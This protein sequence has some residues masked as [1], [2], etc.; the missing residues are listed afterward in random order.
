MI[1]NFFLAFNFSFIPKEQNQKANSLALT[2]ST[3]MP[4]IGP[5]IKYQVEII[6]RTTIPYNIKHWKVFSDDLELQTF[7][8]TIDEFSNISIDHKS[9]EDKNEK[10][11]D[12]QSSHLLKIVAGHDIVELKTNH[13]PRGIVPLEILFERNDVYKGTAMNNQEGEVTECNIGTTENPNIIK[14]SKAL[15]A[16]QKNRYVSL[17]KKFVDTFAWSYEDLK[18]FD[19]DIIQHKIPLK[20]GSKPFKQKIRQFNPMLMSIIEKELKKMLDA[21]IIVPLMYSNWVANLLPIRKKS[22]EIR[23]C[24]DFKNLNK[25]SLKENYPLPKMD[26]IL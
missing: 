20:T 11:E 23:L 25:C 9:Q 2:A 13:I 19:T 22:G 6:H 26:H 4:P 18:T 21:N 16:E 1:D 10:L 14:M 8:H 3:F 17:I 5:N 7:L 24:V 12:Q 15:A